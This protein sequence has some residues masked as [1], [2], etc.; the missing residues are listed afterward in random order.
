MAEIQQVDVARLA[1]V[2][3]N[4]G[5]ETI[6]KP[7]DCN[8]SRVTLKPSSPILI[9]V[10]MYYTTQSQS[11]DMPLIVGRYSTYS[12]AMFHQ[13]LALLVFIGWV[14]TGVSANISVGQHAVECQLTYRHVN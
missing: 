9:L 5:T 2:D 11:T 14:W 13:H 3:M 7:T 1:W 6:F 10:Y 12:Q 8:I 4:N